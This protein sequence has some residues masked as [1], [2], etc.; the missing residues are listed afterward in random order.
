ME[1]LEETLEEMGF[2]DIAPEHLELFAKGY[3][4]SFSTKLH[5]TFIN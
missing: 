1:E 5:L 4:D 3:F 2:K